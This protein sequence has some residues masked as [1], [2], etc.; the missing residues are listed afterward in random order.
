MISN[1]FLSSACCDLF[2]ETHHYVYMCALLAPELFREF[3]S[4]PVFKSL[5]V[6]IRGSVNLNVQAL[7]IQALGVGLKFG[8]LYQKGLK[9]FQ[10]DSSTS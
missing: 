8:R 4:Y 9:A 1:D 6:I 3:Y 10:L 7:V 2:L 5:Y